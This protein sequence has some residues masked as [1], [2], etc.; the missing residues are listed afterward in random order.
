MRVKQD[1]LRPREKLARYGPGHLSSQ[2]LLQVMLGSGSRSCGVESIARRVLP[3]LE[4]WAAR[5][6]SGYEPLLEALRGVPG[7]G[8]AKAAAVAASLELAFRLRDRGGVVIRE[9]GDVMPLLGTLADK[10]QEYFVCITLNGA[11]RLISRRVV[12]IGLA[13]QALVHPREVFAQ[14][15]VERAAKVIVAHN[16]PG[17][18]LRPS[19]EDVQV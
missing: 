1:D 14:A 13:D 3:R 10:K 19:G 15:L 8:G 17:G 7:M 12:T 9:A 2:E 4:E 6:G 16:H 11:N 18:D 5:P